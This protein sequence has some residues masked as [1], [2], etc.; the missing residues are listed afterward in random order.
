MLNSESPYWYG[1]SVLG[2]C[3]EDGSLMMDQLHIHV[4]EDC[5]AHLGWGIYRQS[6]LR[7]I[8]Q[9]AEIYTNLPLA[10]A[11]GLVD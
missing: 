10:K 8:Y 7:G 3:E 6:A 2:L 1:K 9:S 11:S 4:L 5:C